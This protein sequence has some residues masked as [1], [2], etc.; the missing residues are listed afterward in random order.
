MTKN[1]QL[2]RGVE[3][4]DIRYSRECPECEATTFQFERCHECGDIPW[5][6]ENTPSD[7]IYGNGS[8][9]AKTDRKYIN[10]VGGEVPK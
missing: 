8:S 9:E 5:K 4:D 7:S 2:A 3:R 1:E 6:N 10:G